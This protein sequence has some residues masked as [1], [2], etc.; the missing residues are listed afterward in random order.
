MTISVI[1]SFFMLNNNGLKMEIKMCFLIW[2]LNNYENIWFVRNI[3]RAV[4]ESAGTD[5]LYN[6]LPLSITCFIF[7]HRV[8]VHFNICMQALI[9]HWTSFPFPLS[10]SN[11]T[12]ERLSCQSIDRWFLLSIEKKKHNCNYLRWREITDSQHTLDTLLSGNMQNHGQTV[13][14][15][16]K[17]QHKTN[18]G[19]F[20]DTFESVHFSITFCVHIKRL[21]SLFTC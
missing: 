10:H 19:Y 5:L 21:N 8:T 17:L 18:A 11:S 14:S 7:N 12:L 20:R 13:L 9:Q 3:I 1:V 4:S 15:F 6:S 2:I 16:S